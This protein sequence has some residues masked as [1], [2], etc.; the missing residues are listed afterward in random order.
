MKIYKTHRE[1]FDAGR[2]QKAP[3]GKPPELGP[4]VI[5]VVHP[6]LTYPWPRFC[7][8]ASAF[9]V[10]EEIWVM[11][12]NTMWTLLATTEPNLPT[13]QWFGTIDA[14]GGFLLVGAS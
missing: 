7:A 8:L 4:D 2:P 9:V 1:W 5:A 6:A 11:K 12:L 13:D 10:D 14:G 3:Y